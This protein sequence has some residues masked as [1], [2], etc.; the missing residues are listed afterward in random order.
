MPEG[1]VL[2][3]SQLDLGAVIVKEIERGAV[4]PVIVVVVSTRAAGGGDAA[5]PRESGRE[6]C[7]FVLQGLDEPAHQK[8]RSR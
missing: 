3:S 7:T 5:L 8:P 2:V 4:S 1:Q 6:Q